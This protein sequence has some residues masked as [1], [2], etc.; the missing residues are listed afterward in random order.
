MYTPENPPMKRRIP[1]STS[2]IEL[3][4]NGDYPGYPVVRI[5]GKW[6]TD[7]QGEFLM[8]LFPPCD[9]KDGLRA[10]FDYCGAEMVPGSLEHEAFE[11]TLTISIS[12]NGNTTL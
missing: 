10:F 11:G 8:S 1:A 7:E 4:Y 9:A 2:I 3:R 5:N 12:Q 6:L